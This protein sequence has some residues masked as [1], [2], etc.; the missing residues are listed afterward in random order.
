VIA[1]VCRYFN[2]EEEEL[3]SPAKR[4]KISRARAVVGHIATRYLQVC[5]SEAARRLNVDRSVISRAVQRIEHD[6]DLTEAV[7]KMLP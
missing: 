7:R 4:P 5:G 1:A 3:A 6:Q 2:I